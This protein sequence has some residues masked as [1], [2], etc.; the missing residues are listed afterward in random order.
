M[1]PNSLRASFSFMFQTFPA[2][3]SLYRARINFRT[4]SVPSPYPG[5]CAMVSHDEHRVKLLVSKATANKQRTISL[6]QLF[7]LSTTQSDSI[8]HTSQFALLILFFLLFLSSLALPPIYHPSTCLSVLDTMSP[9]HRL[10]AI[11]RPLLR[12]STC[13]SVLDMMSPSHELLAITRPLHHPST[14]LS[15]LDTMSPSHMLLLRRDF[16]IVPPHACPY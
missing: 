13:L 4:P 14:R 5:G 9:S 6:P 7:I 11:L 10:L 16:F 3:F 1:N 12:P 8:L 2:C 15:V